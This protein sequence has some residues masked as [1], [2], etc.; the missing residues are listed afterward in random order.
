MKT[1]QRHYSLLLLQLSLAGAL[2]WGLTQQSSPAPKST[3][4]L[5]AA[6][7]AQPVVEIAGFQRPPGLSTEQ[8]QQ[9]LNRPLFNTSRRPVTSVN[10]LR[11]RKISEPSDW[12]LSGIITSGQTTVAMFKTAEGSKA[13]KP[14]M[15][16]DGWTLTQVS[17]SSV[18][19]QHGHEE[20]QLKLHNPAD[21]S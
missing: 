16:L 20:I 6:S 9:I 18:T 3:R 5:P 8:Q 4:P 1:R 15:R 21:E 10:E 12:Q 13:L 19:L 2:I 17:H 11:Q 7:T 14:G